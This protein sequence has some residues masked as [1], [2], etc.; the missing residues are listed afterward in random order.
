MK[1]LMF[2][3]NVSKTCF[4]DKS[5]Q[6][7]I[8]CDINVLQ[9]KHAQISAMVVELLTH[10]IQGFTSEEVKYIMHDVCT[11]Q[12]TSILIVNVCHYYN[13]CTLIVKSKFLIRPKT[14]DNVKNKKS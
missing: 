9:E 14:W 4:Q 3:Y 12:S 1:H 5:I 11:S 6:K 10:N 7:V 2:K 13:N 8:N